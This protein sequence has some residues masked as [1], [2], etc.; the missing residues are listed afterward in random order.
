MRYSSFRTY[1]D[2]TKYPM[3]RIKWSAL[4]SLVSMVRF[5][6]ITRKSLAAL[7]LIKTTIVT[8]P[9]MATILVAV[10]GKRNQLVAVMIHSFMLTIP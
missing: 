10:L 5:A 1:W 6:T 8:R 4:D 7:L 2:S 3:W 9:L